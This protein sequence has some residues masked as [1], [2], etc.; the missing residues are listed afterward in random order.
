MSLM[1]ENLKKMQSKNSK[2]KQLEV[3]DF[4]ISQYLLDARFSKEEREILFKLRSKT[5]QTKDNF[6]NAY[7][8]NNMLCELCQL[9]P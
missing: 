6:P 3:E 2:S 7:L 4:S 8:N 1:V 5:I 9:F